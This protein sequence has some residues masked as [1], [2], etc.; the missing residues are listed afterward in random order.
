MERSGKNPKEWSEKWSSLQKFWSVHNPENEHGAS[1]AT[2]NTKSFVS[3]AI[4][5]CAIARLQYLGY[6]LRDCHL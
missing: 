5:F 6:R 1:E 2:T 4:D 3:Q